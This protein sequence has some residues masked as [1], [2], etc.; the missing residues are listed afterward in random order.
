[1]KHFS[2]SSLFCHSPI[3]GESN[4]NKN[5]RFRDGSD[6]SI[7]KESTE[8]KFDS[9]LLE[10][11]DQEITKKENLEG[12][13]GEQEP[14]KK[15]INKFSGLNKITSNLFIRIREKSLN[16]TSKI[17]D[18]VIVHKEVLILTLF[19]GGT[20]LV[21]ILIGKKVIILP[22]SKIKWKWPLKS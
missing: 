16:V 6:Y 4:G 21:F 18:F 14:K 3:N 10:V 13:V 7:A 1:M 17:K 5:D 11:K 15:I 12:K 20:I 8:G 22:I 2:F 19:V 9:L